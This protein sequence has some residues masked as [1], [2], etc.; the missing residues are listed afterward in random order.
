MGTRRGNSR[1]IDLLFTLSL[2]CVFAAA[3]LIVVYIGADVYRS[4]IQ[5][6]DL[7]FEVNTTITFVST[8]IRQ[9]D[10]NGGIRVDT[11][12][13]QNALVLE[14]IIGEAVF[15]TW[16]F[17]YD[18]FLREMFINRENTDV[19]A[20][21]AGQELIQVY[22]FDVSISDENIITISA[23]SEDGSYARKLVGIKSAE[24]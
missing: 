13:G 19:L 11:L 12:E 21:W 1:V 10:A 20:L 17:H 15:E 2:F 16:I 23:Q 6:M 3:S 8:K 7:G 9:H 14:H 5:S 24:V 22:A 18:G 4:T